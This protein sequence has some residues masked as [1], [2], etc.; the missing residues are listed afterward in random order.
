[1]D[2]TKEKAPQMVS[3]PKYRIKS[4]AASVMYP[5][6]AEYTQDHLN[7]PHSDIIIK[8]MKKTDAKINKD[9]FSLLIEEVK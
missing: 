8:A 4:G 1:M 9:N 5:G 3:A 6:L 7:G 2:Q